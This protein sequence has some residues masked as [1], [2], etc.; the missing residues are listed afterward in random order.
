M[1]EFT[2]GEG[3]TLAEVGAA[4]PPGMVL[5]DASGIA[6]DP[7]SFFR[8]LAG[9]VLANRPLGATLTEIADAVRAGVLA[10]DDVSVTLIQSGRAKTVAFAG[11]SRLAS[12]LDERQYE[13][14]FGPCVDAAVTGRTI[15]IDDTSDC[16]P[17]PDFARLAQREGVAHV[18]SVGL[19]TLA[20]VSGAV[21]I[22]SH[23]GSGG[24]TREARLVAAG[25]AGYVAVAL[26]NAAL[27][28]GAVDEVAQMQQ[29]MASRAV[30]E[31]AKGMVMRD[32]KCDEETAFVVLRELSMRSNRK[33]RDVAL[34]IVEAARR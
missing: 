27:Y 18:L 22:Y 19:P 8:R 31:Q 14:G 6:G 12:S 24:F 7:A 15:A 3:F 11:D 16:E 29:A 1:S 32:R 28:A 34:E 9:I 17:Y 33:L 21:N 5:P 25:F 20:D 26:T 2:S 4:S 23:K 10:A 30:I 13:S